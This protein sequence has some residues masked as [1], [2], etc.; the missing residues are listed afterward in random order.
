MNN[1]NIN[2]RKS[3]NENSVDNQANNNSNSVK[4]NTLQKKSES[5]LT[6]S[7]THK[8]FIKRNKIDRKENINNDKSAITITKNDKGNRNQTERNDLFS[9]YK[10][11]MRKAKLNQSSSFLYDNPTS[12]NLKKTS[13]V[14]FEKMTG[15]HDEVNFYFKRNLV[16]SV[17]YSPNYLFN[18]S[19]VK[20][21]HFLLI[22]QY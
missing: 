20:S 19:H 6:K 3:R 16:P 1:T 7:S 5:K 10:L 15:R 8:N 12:G 17:S 18:A 13:T 11:N 14:N 21:I 2:C 4:A 9:L 22:N